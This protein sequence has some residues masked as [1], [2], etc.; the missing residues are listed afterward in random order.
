M[1]Y[2]SPNFDDGERV[3]TSPIV[4]GAVADGSVVR[5]GS[6]S[7]YFLNA[8]DAIKTANKNRAIKDLK[9]A[10]PSATI[11]LTRERKE[12]EAR[13]ASQEAKSRPTFSIFGA[14]GGATKPQASRP[15][16]QVPPATTK[17]RP[18]FNIFGAGDQKQPKTSRPI[19]QVPAEKKPEKAPRGVPSIVSWRKNFDGSITGF[20]SGSPNFAEGEKI[21]T[22]PITGGT[23]KA[24]QVVKTG[25]GSRYFLV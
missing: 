19:K 6:G 1:I 7:R 2:G 17:S 11:T 22:S 23:I 18:T 8:D 5:T 16:K 14:G 20:I 10:R 9:A 24:G 3:D 4:S 15:S 12:I 21:T 25:S 13:A